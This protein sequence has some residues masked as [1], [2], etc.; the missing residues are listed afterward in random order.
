MMTNPS[1]ARRRGTILPLLAV[2]LVALCGFVALSIDVGMM[3]VA[4]TQAQNAADLAALSGA[5]SLDGS[6]SSNLTAATANAQ[7]AVTGSQVLSVPMQTSNVA[8]QHGAYHYDSTSQTFYPQY[9]PRRPTT[10]T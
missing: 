1:G 7:A 3:A 10:T 5:R 8:V 4:K 6:P 2:S 9:P